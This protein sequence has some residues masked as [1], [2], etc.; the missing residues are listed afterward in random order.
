[1]VRPLGLEM[2][3]QVPHAVVAG[4]SLGRLKTLRGPRVLGGNLNRPSFKLSPI[5]SLSQAIRSHS[6]RLLSTS[7]KLDLRMANPETTKEVRKYLKQSHDRIFENNKKWAEEM[8]K[9]KP[10][11]FSDLQA[12]QSPDY[13]WIGMSHSHCSTHHLKHT[14]LLFPPHP[15]PPHQHL[16]KC[17]GS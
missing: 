9:K 15:T 12:G 14:H 3:L 16:C 13:L 10:E 17:N 4:R 2:L 8:K 5:A 11:F 6:T 7:S 1:M